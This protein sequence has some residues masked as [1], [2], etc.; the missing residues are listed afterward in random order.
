DV[1]RFEDWDTYDSRIEKPTM[2]ILDLLDGHGVKATFFV[3]GWVAERHPKLVVEIQR[4]GHEI[5]CHGYSHR[6]AYDLSRN[7]FRE[8]TRRAKRLLEDLTGEPVA[9][10]RAASYSIT[11]RSFWALDILIEEGFAYDSSIF[12]IYHDRY[13][14]PEFSRFPEVVRKDGAGE[15][16]EI[17]LTSLR[18]LGKNFPVAGGGYLRLLPVG[19]IQWS[20]RKIN[21]RE[22]RPAVIYFHPWEIDPEQPRLNGSMLSSF[23]H[24]INMDKTF[25]KVSRLLETVRFG[26]IKEAFADELG[27]KA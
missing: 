1:I 18:I 19:F 2:K 21:E 25:S 8:D 15:I 11:K 4:R 10:Y 9:G 3:L 26:T 13:G 5:A 24:R 14:Y 27:G 16:L 12:P 17:P 7:E 22:A 20:I 6:L 23:R